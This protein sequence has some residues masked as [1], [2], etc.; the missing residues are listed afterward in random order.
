MS[1]YGIYYDTVQTN[2][3]NIC[4]KL[5]AANCIELINE[6]YQV[7]KKHMG[8]RNNYCILDRPVI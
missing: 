6:M 3:D 8:P 5:Q 7:N 1:V 2:T 4:L